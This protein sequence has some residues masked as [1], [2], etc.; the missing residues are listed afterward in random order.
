MYACVTVGL[1]LF[2]FALKVAELL[3]TED[4]RDQPNPLASDGLCVVAVEASGRPTFG[5]A[6]GRSAPTTRF[7]GAHALLR[8]LV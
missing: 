7:C 6:G 5:R 8:P 3:V 4:C 2:V 1:H